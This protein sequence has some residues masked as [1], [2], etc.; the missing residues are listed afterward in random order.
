MTARTTF[1][2]AATQSVFSCL[3]VFNE[4][5]V[6]TLLEDVRAGLLKPPRSL[7]PKYFYDSHGSQLFDRICDTREYYVTR[8][9]AGLLQSYADDIILRT[10]P[11]NIIEFGSGTSRKTAYL[12]QACERQAQ[13]CNYW[14]FDVC[15]PILQQAGNQLMSEFDWLNVNALCGDYLAGLANMPNSDGCSLYVFLGST[16]GNFTPSEAGAFLAEVQSH[17]CE[18]DYLLIGADRV[19]DRRVLEAAYNDAQGITA[20]FNLN[21]L[22]V[23]NRELGAEFDVTAF[24]HQAL[25]NDDEQQ[26]EMYLISER[27]QSVNLRALDERLEFAEAERILT[28]ISRKFTPERLAGLINGS[29]LK[30]EIDYEP[31]NQYFSLALCKKPAD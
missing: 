5:T 30:T 15:E 14:P 1:P 12:L 13:Y 18:G 10:R 26:I 31:V 3:P 4:R 11:D 19:K 22:E 17:M 7:P 24:R 6:P 20:L 9:E 27:A 25:Y 21:A 16:I 8:T 28:E 29:G 2:P 23:L